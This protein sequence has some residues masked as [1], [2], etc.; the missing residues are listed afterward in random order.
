MILP[1][2]VDAE[3]FVLGSIMLDDSQFIEVAG[4]LTLDDFSL[5]KH[6]RIFSRM[7]DLQKR[8]EHI[9]RVT[10]AEELQRSG[11]LESC[12]GVS[13]I[14]SLD[15]GLPQSANLD[16]YVR[17][18]QEK[19]TLRSAILACQRTIHRCLG[20]HDGAA[21]ILAEAESILARLGERAWNHDRWLTPESI[22]G[23]HPG[24]VSAFLEPSR[25]GG[26]LSTP[27]PR[28]N[29]STCGL[30][31]G[32]LI[33]IAG[34][35]GMGK[36]CWLLQVCHWAATHGVAAAYV[37][38]E[39]SK[40][41]LVRRLI[42]AD[43][44]IDHQKLR[45]GSL[46][47]DD[48]RR[49][50][51]AASRL[52]E[53]PLCIEDTQVRTVPALAASLRRLAARCTIGVV[54]VDHLQLMR[55]TGRVEKRYLEVGEIVRAL[56]HLAT[57]L[58]VPLLVASQLNRDCETENR[59]PQLSDLRE[60]GEIEQDADIVLFLHRPERY[61]KNLSRADLRGIASFIIAKQRNGPIGEIDMVFLHQFQRFENRA[62]ELSEGLP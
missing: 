41:S 15:D 61:A 27:W 3:R 37:S 4:T 43:A 36:S 23:C 32:D 30:Q 48:R 12:D 25:G 35:P 9:D 60:S 40:E 46:N 29:R 6:R 50:L 19:A 20:A 17:I 5:E 10:V 1:V 55:S 53:M 28:L 34:R 22:M 56:K 49:A 38:L 18:I 52:S 51:L 45:A 14:V 24:G 16:S 7:A 26:G 42:C 58:K 57:D 8:G 44:R 33:V 31:P 59:A 13:Y 47:A 39:M 54:A 21:D 62:D 2:N 11:Q